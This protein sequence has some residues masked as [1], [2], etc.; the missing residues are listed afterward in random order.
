MVG[1]GTRLGLNKIG[2]GLFDKILST[3]NAHLIGYWPLDEIPASQ[4]YLRF[5][6]NNTQVVCGSDASID[7]LH[8]N[9]LTFDAW[10]NL[11]S[12]GE[13][14]GRVIMKGGNFSSGWE[15]FISGAQLY[16]RAFCAGTNAA[17]NTSNADIIGTGWHHVAMTFDDAGDR[18]V[19]LYIDGIA[20]AQNQTA[21]VDAVL[22]DAANNLII[23][24]VSGGSRTLDGSIGWA[25][26][27]D[28]VR[29][30]SGFTAPSRTAIPTVDGNTVALWPMNEGYGTTAHDLSGNGNHGT[31]TDG[32]WGSY[33]AADNAEG[34]AARDGAYHGVRLGQAQ[35]PLVCP[36]FDGVNDYVDIYSASLASAFSGAAGTALIFAKNN[37]WDTSYNIAFRLRVNLNNLIHI[38]QNNTAGQLVWGYKAGGTNEQVTKTGLS[39]VSAWMQLAI[40]WD[41]AGSGDMTAYYNGAQEGTPQ[42]IAGTWAGSLDSSSTIVGASSTTPTEPWSGYLAHCAI[43]TKAL[44]AAQILAIYQASGLT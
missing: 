8:D 27:S 20:I 6:G 19:Y 35:D 2:A 11:N 23:G 37:V 32:D 26:I 5:D 29:W 3:E 22:S 43:W 9:A 4:E 33:P 34:T 25:R 36:Q 12:A 14:A 30:S 13:G 40:T 38:Y 39:G 16:G 24:N 31:I 41:K 17:T 15:M 42:A 21:G 1:I 44:T 7:D 28:N 10:I 18:K